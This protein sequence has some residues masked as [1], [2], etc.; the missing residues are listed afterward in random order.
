[1]PLIYIWFRGTCG[2]Q[3]LLWT[4]IARRWL[5][6]LPIPKKMTTIYVI[7][8]FEGNNK[9]TTAHDLGFDIKPKIE[10]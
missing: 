5:F 2:S 8:W 6:S 3:N 7:W 10:M 1:M 9:Q 4:W